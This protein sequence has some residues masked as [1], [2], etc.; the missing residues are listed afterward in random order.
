MLLALT[1]AGSEGDDG[2]PGA[3]GIDGAAGL[4]CWDLNGIGQAD[5]EEDLNGD[6]VVDVLDCNAIAGGAY[7][8]QAPH[9]GYFTENEYAGTNDCLACR[10]LIGADMLMRAHFTWEGI[11]TNIT[12]QQRWWCILI[13]FFRGARFACLRN[14]LAAECL[15]WWAPGESNPEPAD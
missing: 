7:E 3:D 14:K 12:G 13:A 4:A 8:V 1:I 2:A 10:G 9:A 5:P 15:K 11:A 6:G